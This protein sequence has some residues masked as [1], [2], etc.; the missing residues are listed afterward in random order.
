[1]LK[2][3]L[4]FF[5]TLLPVGVTA[6]GKW[7][8]DVIKLSGAPDNSS[9]RFALCV[10]LMHRGDKRIGFREPKRHYAKLL[11]KA[12]INEVVHSVAQ[13][14]KANQQAEQKAAENAGN[15]K[16]VSAT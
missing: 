10:M 7:A 13:E 3:V 14:I 15:E 6:F 4:S 9:T 1:M 11:Y 2:W 5:P 8:T 16:V 12:S